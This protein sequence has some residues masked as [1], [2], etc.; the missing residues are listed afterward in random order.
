MRICGCGCGCGRRGCA[1]GAAAAVAVASGN[2]ALLR[3]LAAEGCD[4]NAKAVLPAP[5]G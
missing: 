2:A 5:A 4:V 1:R 3:A